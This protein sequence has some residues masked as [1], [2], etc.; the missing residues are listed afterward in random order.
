KMISKL[1]NSILIVRGILIPR[2]I[3]FAKYFTNHHP[4][5]K[6]FHFSVKDYNKKHDGNLRSFQ[7]LPLLRESHV[8]E[9]SPFIQSH[10]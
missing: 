10:W 6:A 2:S 3:K 5:Q 8:E 7:T 1:K 9:L 4:S